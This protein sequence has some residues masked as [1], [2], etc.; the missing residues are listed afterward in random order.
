M[1]FYMSEDTI[2]RGSL[3]AKLAVAPLAIGAFAALQAEADAKAPQKAVMYQDAPKD[4]KRCDQCKFYIWNKKDKKAKGGCTQVSG[5][6][7]PAGYCVV[8]A[9]GNNKMNK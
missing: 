7:A 4:G 3:L 8:W 2:S 1:R 5:Q 6:I 9:A